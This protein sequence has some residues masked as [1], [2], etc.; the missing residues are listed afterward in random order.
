[1]HGAP[2]SCRGFGVGL[3]CDDAN[4]PLIAHDTIYRFVGH[5]TGTTF[6]SRFGQYTQGGCRAN[7][8]SRRR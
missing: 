4:L 6:Q 7:T 8:R 2:T 5:S 3:R 1:M